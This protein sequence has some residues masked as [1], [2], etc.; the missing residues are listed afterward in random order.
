MPGFLLNAASTVLCAHGGQAKPSMPMPRVMVDGKPVVVQPAPH[1]VSACSFV[2]S[3][4]P[5]PCVMAQWVMGASRVTVMG[6]PVLLADSKA[7]C[8]PNGTPVNIIAGQ[9]KVQGM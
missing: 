4:A 3:G 8:P 5:M 6:Q 2:V 7:V 1:V 9:S